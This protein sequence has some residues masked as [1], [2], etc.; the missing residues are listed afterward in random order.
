[1]YLLEKCIGICV[2][3]WVGWWPREHV[4]DC[5]AL[6]PRRGLGQYLDKGGR[7]AY[8]ERVEL[9]RAMAII[10]LEWTPIDPSTFGEVRINRH[11]ANF[12]ILHHIHI[13]HGGK[14]WVSMG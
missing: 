12:G 13:R 9:A 8:E 14:H 2:L 10:P 1:M 4:V 11:P 7:T 5:L 6:V 3:G